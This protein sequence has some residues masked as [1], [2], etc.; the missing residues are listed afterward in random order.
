MEIPSKLN[1]MDLPEETRSTCMLAEHG[2][3]LLHSPSVYDFILSRGPRL[4]R[5]RFL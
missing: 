2:A 3:L 4:V 1:G 5:V